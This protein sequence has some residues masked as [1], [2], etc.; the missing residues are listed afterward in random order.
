MERPDRLKDRGFCMPGRKKGRGRSPL[1]TAQEEGQSM[2]E[3]T[4][5]V[6]FL[7]LIILILFEMALLFYS[8]IALL[9]ASRE[10]AVYASL[11]PDIADTTDP[12]YSQYESIVAAEAQAAGL[13]T[14]P[15]VFE[16]FLPET[17]Q[18][19]DPLDPVIVKVSYQII[20][21]TQGIVLPMLGRMGLFQSA[22]MTA[23][24]EMPIR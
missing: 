1:W 24:T 22:W 23:R 9:N 2:L 10:G 7:V 4:F 8:Y 11:Y 14:D 20:N 13:N 5:G 18:G 3:M 12:H 17:P 15:A 19:I 21:P 16:V 6:I